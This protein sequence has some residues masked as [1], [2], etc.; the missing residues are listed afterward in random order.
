MMLCNRYP[1]ASFG[2]KNQFWQEKTDL[3]AWNCGVLGNWVAVF[4]FEFWDFINL[5]IIFDYVFTFFGKSV[6]YLLSGMIL[7][8]K[9]TNRAI[10][11][12]HRASFKHQY[13]KRK[14]LHVTGYIFNLNKNGFVSVFSFLEQHLICSVLYLVQRYL[15]VL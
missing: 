15:S 2:G 10:S 7:S 8:T 11:I 1:Y 9:T 12:C 5:V 6:I 3:W 4:N 14:T 13:D